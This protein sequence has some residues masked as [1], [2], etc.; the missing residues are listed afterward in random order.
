MI[1]TYSPSLTVP[2]TRECINHCVYCGYR[3]DGDGLLPMDAIKKMVCKARREGVSEV[4][5]MSGEKADKTPR[6]RKGLDALGMASLVSWV[7]NICEYLLKENLLPHINMGTLDEASLKR[8]SDVSASMG[9]MLEGVNPRVNARVHPGKDIKRRCATMEAAGRL[10]IP[11]TTGILMGVGESQNDRL[12]SL[13]VIKDI[14]EKYGHIQE[15]I[16]Q[17]YAPNSHSRILP[18]ETSLNDMKELI[19][20]CRA[21]LPG[22]SVQVPPN[23][24][25]NWEKLVTLGVDDLG[26]IGSEGDLINPESPWPD[27]PTLARVVRG[28]GGVLKKRLPIYPRFYRLGWYSEKVGKTLLNWIE[29]NNDYRY[30]SH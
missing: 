22:V 11:F 1:V 23:L 9:L 24:D 30:Y 12:E 4:L 27:I 16:L 8:L 25:A 19:L 2:V 18:R 21:Y 15:V 17:Q 20:F 13:S 6:V 7:R 29:E 3:R 28:S 26:G 5:V 10:A 14:N